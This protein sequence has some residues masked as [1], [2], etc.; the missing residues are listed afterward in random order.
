[1]PVDFQREFTDETLEKAPI[2]ATRFL[3]GIA[4]IPEIRAI[5][6]DAGMTD[7]QIGEGKDLLV[8]AI[9]APTP[10]SPVTD[11]PTAQAARAASA[12][13][14][15]YDELH[16]AGNCRGVGTALP[17]CGGLRHGWR[18]NLGCGFRGSKLSGD[19][20]SP[21]EPPRETGPIQIV[22]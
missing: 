7:A 6:G 20:A 18:V 13:I 14:N 15:N 3:A 2:E 17:K 4:A 5:M 10:T 8:K 11:T 1:M 21:S 19:P 16:F 22:H 9:S 12:E